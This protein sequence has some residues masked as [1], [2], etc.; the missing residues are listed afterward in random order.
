M[1]TDIRH[2]GCMTQRL[3]AMTCI[4]S[5]LDS[6][7]SILSLYFSCSRSDVFDN[8]SCMMNWH[9]LPL[10]SKSNLLEK[11][12]FSLGKFSLYWYHIRVIIHV[13]LRVKIGLFL[14]YLLQDRW[15]NY[16]TF[17]N[18]PFPIL[19][20]EKVSERNH[21][22]QKQILINP[23][24]QMKFPG[25]NIRSFLFFSFSTDEKRR[26]WVHTFQNQQKRGNYCS[27]QRWYPWV[28]SFEIRHL[29]MM[30]QGLVSYLYCSLQIHTPRTGCE[31]YLRW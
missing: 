22:D 7:W 29:E 4:L 23:F 27:F 21:T 26:D 17:E 30:S 25:E 16:R 10:F 20:C 9:C 19:Y 2:D 24:L 5:F 12:S 14:F 15:R 28:C 1:H 18:R 8:N 11:M 6:S 31:K 3:S 13:C